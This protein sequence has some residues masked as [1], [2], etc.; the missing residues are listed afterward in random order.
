[1]RNKWQNF[2]SN[3]SSLVLWIPSWLLK[4]ADDCNWLVE[5]SLFKASPVFIIACLRL[6]SS[7]IFELF[8]FTKKV[9]ASCA[10]LNFLFD[11]SSSDISSK[12]LL[13][14]LIKG[15]ALIGFFLPFVSPLSN[16]VCEYLYHIAIFTMMRAEATRSTFN[17]G[18]NLKAPGGYVS[19]F[20]IIV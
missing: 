18:F 7:S 20:S 9:N 4:P 16:N 1:M 2:C 14:C 15:S 13:R 11:L 5:I 17:D 12:N 10:A 19:L 3:R 6:C 8:K